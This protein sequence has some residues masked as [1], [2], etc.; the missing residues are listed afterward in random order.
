[1]QT[2]THTIKITEC[3]GE[4]EILVKYLSIQSS[5]KKKRIQNNYSPNN[6]Q[7]VHQKNSVFFLYQRR[8][9]FAIF[10]VSQKEKERKKQLYKIKS[11]QKAT[12]VGNGAYDMQNRGG[13]DDVFVG[14]QSAVG[15]CR[16]PAGFDMSHRFLC[17]FAGFTSASLI[18]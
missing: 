18:Y 9:I 11:S 4:K 13:C 17:F 5:P 10:V 15:M 3:L 1:M 6:I 2:H 7:Y 8:N 14:R 12:T 16:A